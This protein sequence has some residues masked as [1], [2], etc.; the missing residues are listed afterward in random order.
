MGA[1]SSAVLAEI[2][3][4]FIKCKNV[5]DILLKHKIL[6][7]YRYVDDIL[8]IYRKDFYFV[9]RFQGDRGA[10]CREA[11][12]NFADESAYLTTD[13]VRND[14]VNNSQNRGSF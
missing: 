10:A 2:Y 14:V 9:H 6:G 13:N 4:Q 7:Y 12:I 8:L 11:H 1:P 5:Y 3:L